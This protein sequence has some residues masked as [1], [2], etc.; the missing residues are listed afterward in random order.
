MHIIDF[1]SHILPG[2][3]DGST[4]MEMSERMLEMYAA[5]GTTTVIATPHFY[6]ERMSLEE[7]L[8]KRTSSHGRLQAA[9]EI[10]GIH[11]IPGSEVAFFSGMSNAEDLE[12]LTI[13]GTSLL[14]L[15]M[16]F[17]PWTDRDLL[18]VERLTV[19]GLKPVIAHIERFYSCQ[20]RKSVLEDL[21][22]L[23]VLI[24]INAGALLNR[25]TRRLALK[26]FQKGK[27][28]LLGSD[29]HNSNSRPPNLGAG[30]KIL[31]RPGDPYL[32]IIDQLGEEVLKLK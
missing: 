29:C 27:A 9:A 15:E 18:E 1:H 31:E 19:R 13:S 5:D 21:Y 3:D 8:Q 12:K 10:H 4:D 32:F 20:K 30:R 24:Q 7:F 17:R 28:H 11:L 16:P 26:L 14:L 22:S 2:M 23:P 25:R 6:A